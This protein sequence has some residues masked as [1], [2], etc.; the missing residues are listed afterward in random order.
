MLAV[1]PPSYVELIV[2]WII[3]VNLADVVYFA[4]HV[5]GEHVKLG[6]P[7]CSFSF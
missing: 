7:P 4:Y 5:Y 6:W 2:D 1:R 3:A